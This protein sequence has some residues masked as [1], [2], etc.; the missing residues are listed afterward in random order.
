MDKKKIS[1]WVLYDFSNSIVV[2][3]FALYFSQW[4]V[5]EKHFSDM[6]YNLIYVGATLLLIPTA[7]VLGILADK[8]GYKLPFLRAATFFLFIF[9]LIASI[10]AMATKSSPAIILMAALAF[11]LA[12]YFYQL[13]FT[14]YNPILADIAPAEKQGN[15]SGLGQAAN[16]LGQLAGIL[17]VL[18]FV[19]GAVY[20]FGN[21][22]RAQALL[23]ATIAFFLLSLP[24]LLFY[25]DASAAEPLK[26]NVLTEL[27]A[28]IKNFLQLARLPGVGWYLL[29][30][31]FFNDAILTM[32]NNFAIY[33]QEVFH[34]SDKA[35]SVLMLIVLSCSA[36][37]AIIGGRIADKA[38]LKRTLIAILIAWIIIFPLL[39]L[40]PTFNYFAGA[41]ALMGLFYGATWTVT[42]AVLLALVPK[43][44][45]NHAFGFYSISDRF[46][47]LVGP[48]VWGIIASQLAYL[49][50]VKYKIGTIALWVF[51]IIGFL[52]IKKIPDVAVRQDC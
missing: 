46:S 43:N 49:G 10:L 26:A 28:Y 30:F 29:G 15:I 20:F 2:I 21:H 42:R 4:L 16:W 22:G 5:V 9:S 44:R 33:M 48:L 47:S 13:S 1:L 11:L 34:A 12:N 8:R 45:H 23:P 6:G 19:T 17:L 24:L 36:G 52:L 27:K 14:F 25:K 40:A 35:K 50:T 31:F 38:G 39:G 32:E 18:P 37:G 51:I 41:G 3:A 7:P